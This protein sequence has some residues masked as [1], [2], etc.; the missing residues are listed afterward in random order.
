M[1]KEPHT[2]RVSDWL[3]T[4]NIVPCSGLT[5]SGGTWGRESKKLRVLESEEVHKSYRESQQKTDGTLQ[6]G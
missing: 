4:G 3:V 1:E 5:G 6:F 2:P